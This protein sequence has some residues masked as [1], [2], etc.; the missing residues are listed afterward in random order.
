MGLRVL[1]LTFKARAMSPVRLELGPGSAMA[2][3]KFFSL[4]VR[5]SKRTL[6]KFSS[7]L[8]ITVSVAF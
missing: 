6:K 4:G 8:L 1:A 5:R 7:R 2:R 3:R